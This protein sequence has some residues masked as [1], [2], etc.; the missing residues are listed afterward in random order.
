M[1]RS[2]REGRLSRAGLAEREP[3]GRE[4]SSGRRTGGTSP[5]G[6][7]KSRRWPS[8]Q[9]EQVGKAG[10]LEH[11]GRR[12]RAGA[13]L[14]CMPRAEGLRLMASERKRAERVDEGG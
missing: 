5:P 2:D 14:D 4:E 1:G 6:R 3:E 10:A 11:R 13:G 8:G 9:A 7:G 12:G